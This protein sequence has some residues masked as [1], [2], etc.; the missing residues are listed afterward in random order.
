M[1]VSIERGLQAHFYQPDGTS[2]PGTEWSVAI[3]D[4][5]VLVRAYADETAGLTTADE[6]AAVIAFVESK[7]AAGWRPADA[8]EPLTLPKRSKPSSSPTVAAESSPS[9]PYW[10]PAKR[11]G[12]G[13]GPPTRWEGWAVMAGYIVV[14]TI[15]GIVLAPRSMPLFF[16]F[17]LVSVGVMIA[18]CYA[19]G[20]P[21]RWRWGE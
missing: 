20:E 15:A 21:P 14:L 2:R 18:V 17:A 3:D 4:A 11:Y 7:L 19:K 5:H 9:S 6:A 13:W 8:G 16:A 12:W 10:F 1:N